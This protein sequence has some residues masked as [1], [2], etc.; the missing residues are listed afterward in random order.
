MHGLTIKFAH[1]PPYACRGSSGQ[2]PECGLM[3]LA[4]WYFTPMLLLNYGSL[5]LSGVYYCLS[6]FWC[7]VT[8]LS[9]LFVKLGKSESKIREMF[10]QVYRDNAMKKTAV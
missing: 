6:V 9:E 2:K 4:Y 10:V 7:A 3:T 5:F 8:R 1:L